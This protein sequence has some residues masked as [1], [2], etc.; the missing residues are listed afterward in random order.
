MKHK[1]LILTAFLYALTAFFVPKVN[2]AIFF[3]IF[4]YAMLPERSVI[5]LHK[6]D[7]GNPFIF[8]IIG[9]TIVNLVFIY[10]L[11]LLI[12]KIRQKRAEKTP[13][14]TEK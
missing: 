3:F 10:L 11:G 9:S 8:V 4:F 12:L 2:F 1:Y 6:L 7:V 5:F 14:G 13:E